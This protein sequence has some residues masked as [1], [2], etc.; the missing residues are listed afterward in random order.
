[1]Q[2]KPLGFT[3]LTNLEY[4]FLFNEGG[5]NLVSFF[6]T[7]R[8]HKKGAVIKKIGKKGVTATIS[9]ATGLSRT[10]IERYLSK[11]LDFGLVVLHKNGNVAVKGRKW[12][13]RHLPKQ[14]KLKLLPMLIY[15]KFTDTKM[16]SRYIRVHSNLKSQIPQ[17][18]KR[19]ERIKLLEE[20]TSGSTKKLSDLKRAKQLEKDGLTVADLAES[21]LNSTLSNLGFDKLIRPSENKNTK[22]AGNYHKSKML[23]SNLINQKRVIELKYPGIQNKK[24]AKEMSEDDDFKGGA[25]VTSKGICV[26]SSPHISI[27]SLTPLSRFKKKAS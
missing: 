19:T 7:L 9:A 10:A 11:L 21:R 14:R 17:I 1:M 18:V 25:F 12:T 20:L 23:G 4:N 16:S 26:E 15:S 13:Y 2:P 24:F 6:A 5:D 22:S 8:F 3:L 27:S